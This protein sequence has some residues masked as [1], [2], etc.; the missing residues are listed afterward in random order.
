MSEKVPVTKKIFGKQS[1]AT[2]V[3]TQFKQLVPKDSSTGADTKTVPKFFQDYEELFYDIPTTG[4]VDS[5]LYIVN[6][7]SEILGISLEDLTTELQQLRDQNV[8]LK[9]QLFVATKK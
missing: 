3:D 2:V 6:R 5:H 9:N 8:S 4:S 7:S 1:F